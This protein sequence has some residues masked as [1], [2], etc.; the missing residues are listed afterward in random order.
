MCGIF[1]IYNE[2]TSSEKYLNR[3]NFKEFV[4]IGNRS[5][6][7]GLDASGIV[8][9][10]SDKIEIVK[11]D[12]DFK[13][14]SR[15][16]YQYTDGTYLLAGHTRLATHGSSRNQ[17]NNHPII[18]ENWIVIH[19]GWVTNY[20]DFFGNSSD[21]SVVDSYS[22]N[23]VL[24]NFLSSKSQIDLQLLRNEM[25]RLKGEIT[26]FAMNKSG[27][28]FLYTNVGNLYILRKNDTVIFASEPDFLPDIRDTNVIKLN[29]NKI[30]ILNNYFENK[31][32]GLN[33]LN[34]EATKTNSTNS[35]SQ[36]PSENLVNQLNSRFAEIQLRRKHLKFC[37]RCLLPETFPNITFNL[38]GICH[39]CIEF[40]S[41]KHLTE[42]ELKNV[43]DKLFNE[44]KKMVIGLSGGRD[45]CY[46]LHLLSKFEYEP[47]AV[48]YD[49]GLISNSARENMA[50]ITGLL[51]IEHILIARKAIEVK[52]RT[53][54]TLKVILES[55]DHRFI[56]MLMAGDKSWIKQAKKIALKRGGLP[57][58]MG[59]QKYENTGFK[60]IGLLESTKFSL[61]TAN[62]SSKLPLKLLLRLGISYMLFGLRH[63]SILPVLITE[64]LTG[65]V[66]YYFGN[67]KIILPLNYI[68]YDVDEVEK[69]LSET[70]DFKF[71]TLQKFNSWRAGDMTSHLYNLLYF[72]KLN[73]TEQDVMVSN[74]IR[75]GKIDIH[76]GL[77]RINEI[78]RANL[79]LL[80]EYCEYLEVDLNWVLK[81]IIEF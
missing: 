23:L 39:H 1:G 58:L 15:S 2:S 65:F 45:S 33:I 17:F 50:N 22:I 13:D 40:S 76:E 71:K 64:G 29:K 48:T 53:R 38:D 66:N 79:L 67:S 3:K 81:K 56:P 41:E 32:K 44:S 42:N 68:D 49:W 70:Y 73:F 77:R 19:N 31:E 35:N 63:P 51:G 16:H 57:V 14:L 25:S 10:K 43:L 21:D 60:T 4:K 8:T 62:L 30:F 18:S 55:Q 5:R 78:D 28:S 54:K 11:G 46:L 27:F 12:V 7:R 34:V 72:I 74:L 61:T 36:V 80:K 6:R 75:H 26:I 20:K 9:L 59:I 24:E 47:I 69:V 37:R 52:R